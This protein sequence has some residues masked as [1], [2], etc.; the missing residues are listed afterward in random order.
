M[1]QE[2]FTATKPSVEALKYILTVP[3]GFDP[4]K[5]SLPLIIFLHGAGERGSDIELVKRHGIPKYFS[6]DPD[7]LGLRAVTLSPQCPDGMIWN[8]IITSVKELADRTIAEYSIDKTA[9]AV[10]GIS[11]GG[12]GTWAFGMRYPDFISKLA[13]VCGGGVSWNVGVLRN[14]PVRAFHGMDD[15]TVPVRNTMEM[16]DRLNGCGGN[17]VA[18]YYPGVGHNSWDPAYETSD[19]IAWLATK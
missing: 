7:Y 12:Y 2:T 13:P 3:T 5:E 15:T 17:A 18:T 19:V 14:V 8:D 16:V 10:T 11:M 4:A 9:V 6:K 1:I